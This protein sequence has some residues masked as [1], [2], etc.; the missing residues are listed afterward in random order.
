[1]DPWYCYINAV[2]F[3]SEKRNPKLC[4]PP[5]SD[6]ILLVRSFNCSEFFIPNNSLPTNVSPIMHLLYSSRI[7]TQR[8][9]SQ[10]DVDF[11]FQCGPVNNAP[12][13]INK[14]IQSEDELQ[15]KDLIQQGCDV[16]AMDCVSCM[17]S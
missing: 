6:Y 15:V 11:L 8:E 17:S 14:A 5:F 16:N 12:P 1:M 7:V 10:C 13:P 2:Q 3:F 4:T 9:C